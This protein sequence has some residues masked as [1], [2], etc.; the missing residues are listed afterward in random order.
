MSTFADIIERKKPDIVA[1]FTERARARGAATSLSNA[2]IADS[3]YDFLDDLVAALRAP[4]T[5]TGRTRSAG[6]HGAQRFAIGYDIGA[7]VREYG[8]VRDL[9]FDLA[10][11]NDHAASEGDLRT[12]ARFIVDAIADAATE[13]SVDRDRHVRD[14]T[15]TRVAFFAHELRNP[16]G[17]A[18]MALSL[19]RE[20]GDLPSSPVADT[21][22][23]SLGRMGRLIDDALVSIS[24]HEPRPLAYETFD[25]SVLLRQLANDITA[26]ADA[27]SQTITIEGSARIRADARTLGSALSNLVRNAVKF[28][29]HGGEIHVRVKEAEARVSIE[30]EDSCGGL[31]PDVAHK[32]FDPF[33]QAGADR[34][35]FGLGLAI[36]EQAVQAHHGTLRVHDL[37]GRGCVF[38]L[39]L[40][41]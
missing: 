37:P 32:L 33:V 40:P 15:R 24:L 17:S 26:E 25:V 16:L 36:A 23:R 12:L 21:M 13:Y 41:A 9:L 6:E 28:S 4:A 39:E 2:V 11:A 19:L 30:I 18:R 22:E 27:K 34:S 8:I 31:P 3:L 20:R 10:Q 35:G 29:R 5:R 14:V 1:A 38:V 7:V